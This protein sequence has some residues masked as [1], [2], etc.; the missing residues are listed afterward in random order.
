MINVSSKTRKIIRLARKSLGLTPPGRRVR[1]KNSDTFVTSYPKSGNTW[2][3]FLVANML[4]PDGTTDFKN[5]N[6]RVPDIYTLPS[7]TLGTIPEPRILK[8]HEY[9]DPRY[10]KTL[11]IVRD[12]RSVLVSYY[13]H[14]KLSG[15]IDSSTSIDEFADLFMSGAADSFGDWQDNVTSWVKVREKSVDSFRMLKYEDIKTD[16]YSSCVKIYE[17][18]NLEFAESDVHRSLEL[19]DF[20]RMKKLENKGI[21]ASVLAR[22]SG[23]P[24]TGYIR[25]GKTEGWRDEIPTATLEK[26]NEKYKDLLQELGYSI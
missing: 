18:L 9:F 5:I 24:A 21:D 17:F 7:R 2:V 20:G 15:R 25:A 12:V 19:S 23:K 11:Y 26:L 13:H 16:P 10:R 8:S 22:T 6:T 1:V 4:F 14:M 3:R